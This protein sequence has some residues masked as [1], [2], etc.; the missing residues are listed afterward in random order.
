MSID[1]F[2]FY[3]TTSIFIVIYSNKIYIYF[4]KSNVF[5]QAALLIDSFNNE[6]ISHILVAHFSS[7]RKIEI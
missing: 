5:K 4:K 7:M 6:T 3:L 1:E 2:Q